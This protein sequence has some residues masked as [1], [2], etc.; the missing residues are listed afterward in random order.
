[1]KLLIYQACKKDNFSYSEQKDDHFPTPRDL[2]L[3]AAIRNSEL[4]YPISY[5][6]P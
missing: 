6:F 5:S 2:F 3:L 1:M 4:F